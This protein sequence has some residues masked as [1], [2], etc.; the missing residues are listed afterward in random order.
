MVD[1]E[2]IAQ[3]KTSPHSGLCTGETRGSGHLGACG[4]KDRSLLIPP[5]RTL[6]VDVSTALLELSTSDCSPTMQRVDFTF[7][8]PQN[9][10]GEWVG[11]G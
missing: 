10:W 3:M 6:A 5:Q 8:L 9:G 7:V 2:S 1:K 4:A 11:L